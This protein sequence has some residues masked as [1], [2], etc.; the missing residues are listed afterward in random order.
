MDGPRKCHPEGNK[1]DRGERSYD[2][3]YMG[4]LKRND[5]DELRKQ[6]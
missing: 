4:N 1:S 6:K 2:I 3:L 5:N